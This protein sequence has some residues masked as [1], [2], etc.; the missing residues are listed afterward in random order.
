MTDLQFA[1]EILDQQPELRG[2]TLF[3]V[4]FRP[5]LEKYR[6]TLK[7]IHKTIHLPK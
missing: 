1:D 2:K 5:K 7:K 3:E 4:L 6:L